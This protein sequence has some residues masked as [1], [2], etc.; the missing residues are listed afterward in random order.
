MKAGFVQFMPRFGEID[1]NLRRVKELIQG[2]KADLLVLPELFNTGYLFSSKAE[3]FSLAEEI[4]GGKTTRWLCDI[5]KQDDVF[6]IGGVA[7]R[8]GKNIFNSAVVVSPQGYIGTYRKV[9]LFFEEKLWF[10]PG[11]NGFA[12]YDIGKWRIGIMICFD[13]FFPESMRILSLMGADVICHPANLVL[14]FCQEGMKIR[15]LENHV[16]AVTANRTGAEN[17]GERSLHF[18]GKSQITGPESNILYKAAEA[19]E[20]VG[21]ADIDLKS[22]RDK[23]INGYND[24]I[25]DRRTELYGNLGVI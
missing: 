12:V 22:A 18:T 8:S 13:W 9:H 17:R 15:C 16:F 11:D 5:A 2:T 6:L 7:E 3:A 21:I 25:A 10:E 23:K 24:I 1:Q 14:P 4:P 19:T 20:D